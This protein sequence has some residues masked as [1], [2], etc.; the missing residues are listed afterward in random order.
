MFFR[1]IPFFLAILWLSA[2]S[3]VSAAT[4]SGLI[5]QETKILGA[6]QACGEESVSESKF[7]S[8]FMSR[9]A[10]YLAAQHGFPLQMV[11]RLVREH[12]YEGISMGRQVAEANP[13]VCSSV[14]KEFRAF[15]RNFGIDDD[16]VNQA[17]E[18]SKQEKVAAVE[19]EKQER[20]AAKEREKQGRIA[21]EKKERERIDARN[22]MLE[23][24]DADRM[25]EQE[26]IAAEEEKRARIAAEEEEK[27]KRELDAMA[28]TNSIGME[29]MPIS[30]GSFKR[31]L[32]VPIKDTFGEILADSRTII[33]SKPFYLG[34]YE[35]TQEQWV[36]VMGN[37]PSRFKGRPNPVDQ[38]SWND[39]QEFINRLNAKE[40][41]NRY[42]LPTEAEWELAARGGTETM[43]FF[44]KT[45]ESAMEDVRDVSRQMDAYAWFNFNSR[46]T[47]HP[48]GQK[49]PNPYGLYDV[50]GNVYEWVQ[51]WYASDLPA[52]LEIKDYRG[53]ASGSGRVLLGCS[54]D[55]NVDSC[56]SA[57][58]RSSSQ[59]ARS[60]Y[61]GFRLALSQE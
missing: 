14:K 58:R 40:G 56:R 25:K 18:R 28:W 16:A 60:D 24:L 23:K 45:D 36:A 51:D 12:M 38:V 2:A 1:K 48:V 3:P 47:T 33:I 59:G 4:L 57:G 39:V 6:A 13:N 53:P 54:W 41:H 8:D 11:T 9:Y 26:R 7:R 27:R 21:A 35:V 52:D 50:Y 46:G 32:N 43:F 42:R 29:F 10:N 31:K 61:I 19:R 44:M 49:K 30:S 20:I 5:E 37:N 55:N 17:R 22:K 34:R 15:M